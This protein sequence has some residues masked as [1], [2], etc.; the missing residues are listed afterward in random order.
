VIRIR[1]LFWLFAASFLLLGTTHAQTSITISLSNGTVNWSNL[2]P[3][4]ATN[5]GSG[6]VSVTTSWSL[7]PAG[8]GDNLKVY[9]YFTAP[10]AALA[11]Q[12]V[13]TTGCPDIPSSAFEI[14]VNTLAFQAVTATSPFSAGGSLNIISQ[15]VTGANKNSSRV[16]TLSFNINLST[17]PNLPADSY[18]GLLNITAQSLP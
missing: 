9:A 12:S 6:T 17:L 10:S 16:D 18:K 2:I 11:H 7:S 14:K 5:A 8:G 1:T 13:C 15:P 4:S 3:G